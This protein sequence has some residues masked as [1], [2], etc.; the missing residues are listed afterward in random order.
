MRYAWIAL[1]MWAS[2]ASAQSQLEF[3]VRVRAYLEQIADTA[4]VE[5]ARCVL[6]TWYGDTLRFDGIA[7]AP[8]IE[9]DASADAVAVNWG[10]C[11]GATR[12]IWHNHI[13]LDAQHTKQE[14]CYASRL[15]EEKMLNPTFPPV[16]FVSVGSGV[17]CAFML[18]GADRQMRQLPWHPADVERESVRPSDRTRARKPEWQADLPLWHAPASASEL[19]T[20]QTPIVTGAQCVQLVASQRLSVVRCV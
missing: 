19:P 10:L 13:Y 4:T 5:H 16:L 17:S 2:A 18:V 12:A 1:L 20:T 15:D 8:W 6:A 14:H 11:P 7:E 9:S 3:D